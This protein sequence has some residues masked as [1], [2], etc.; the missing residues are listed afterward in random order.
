MKAPRHPQ[1][2][3]GEKVKRKSLLVA[4]TAHGHQHFPL[5]S[6]NELYTQLGQ[7][8]HH[9]HI[10]DRTATTKHEEQEAEALR[11]LSA[12]KHHAAVALLEDVVSDRV[13]KGMSCWRQAERLVMLC[14]KAACIW[15]HSEQ[16]HESPE[17]LFSKAFTI[18]STSDAF[19]GFRPLRSTLLST[20]LNNQAVYQ[21]EILCNHS[22]AEEL[23]QKAHSVEG[24]NPSAVTLMNMAALCCVGMEEEGGVEVEKARTALR[25]AMQAA[26]ISEYFVKVERIGAAVPQ[27]VEM[28][29]RFYDDH[30]TQLATSQFI[31]ARLRH[32]LNETDQ[33]TLLMQAALHTA[34]SGLPPTHPLIK[35]IRDESDAY[36]NPSARPSPIPLLLQDPQA[37]NPPS[38][39]LP[40]MLRVPLPADILSGLPA[41][42][43]AGVHLPAIE[44]RPVSDGQAPQEYL[45]SDP[46]RY[47]RMC[48]IHQLSA[49]LDERFRKQQIPTGGIERENRRGVAAIPP[50]RS[51]QS[52]MPEDAGID[53]MRVRTPQ[54][55]NGYTT[56]SDSFLPDAVRAG[57]RPSP[58][59]E[60]KERRKEPRPPSQ[61][62]SGLQDGRHTPGRGRQLTRQ[63]SPY[64]TAPVRPIKR[65][66]QQR[67]VPVR[68]QAFLHSRPTSQPSSTRQYDAVSVA[69]SI[70]SEVIPPIPPVPTPPSTPL[71]ENSQKKGKDAIT[72]EEWSIYEALKDEISQMEQGEVQGGLNSSVMSVASEP[73]TPDNVVLEAE[74][75]ELEV[76]MIRAFSIAFWVFKACRV[77]EAGVMKMRRD[78]AVRKRNE[79][80]IIVVQRQCRRHVETQRALRV[81]AEKRVVRKRS[82]ARFLLSRV[83]AAAVARNVCTTLLFKQRALREA[84]RLRVKQ[85]HHAATK[86]QTR[87]RGCLCRAHLTKREHAI[88]VLQRTARLYAA[89]N[90]LLRVVAGKRR[91]RVLY[92]S[93]NA[94]ATK[95]CHAWR[96]MLVCRQARHILLQRKVQYVD[97]RNTREAVESKQVHDDALCTAHR[98]AIIVQRCA[99][100]RL[101]TRHVLR[102]HSTLLRRTVSACTVQNAW[103]GHLSY[104]FQMSQQDLSL[105]LHRMLARCELL[106]E[107]AIDIQRVIRGF[108][109]RKAARLVQEWN[110]LLAVKA[111]TVQRV[112]RGYLGR[113]HYD[114]V[115][116]DRETVRLQYMVHAREAYSAVLVQ[117]TY[118]RFVDRRG[119]HY[120]KETKGTIERM[121]K[122]IQACLL[123]WR[124][125]KYAAERRAVRDAR[126]KR[127]LTTELEVWSA[128][129]IQRWWRICLPNIHPRPHRAPSTKEYVIREALL[130]SVVLLQ[131]C[132]RGWLARK[133]EPKRAAVR[134][135][136]QYRSY[137]LK[138][139]HMWRKRCIVV[140]RDAQMAAAERRIEGVQHNPNI[141]TGLVGCL[142]VDVSLQCEAHSTALC[143][144]LYNQC[145][146][147]PMVTTTPPPVV[148]ARLTPMQFIASNA[149]CVPH[150]RVMVMYAAVN[151]IGEWWGEREVE[152]RRRGQ[153]RA[154]RH[155]V[156][157]K[158]LWRRACR[159]V[160]AVQRRE[161]GRIQRVWRGYTGRQMAHRSRADRRRALLGKA[162]QDR[163]F[164][165][166]HVSAPSLPLPNELSLEDEVVLYAHWCALLIQRWFRK[167]IARSAVLEQRSAYVLSLAAYDDFEGL[168]FCATLIQKTYRGLRERRR[169][170]RMHKAA[171]VIQ[172]IVLIIDAKRR[173]A[174]QR[175]R[176]LLYFMEVQETEF[177][178]DPSDSVSDE[179]N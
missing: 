139:D 88:S 111:T 19:L 143:R 168:V 119:V 43:F 176:R 31:Q 113:K 37:N 64:E 13:H 34:S 73:E 106:Q 87:W 33:A 153:K 44:A 138:L 145:G 81:V 136:L 11:L 83:C 164:V 32:L 134:C 122:R 7:P 152:R 107:S 66:D 20:I 16:L 54:K 114:T 55:S 161:A 156:Y 94:A 167:I 42:P 6:K 166:K 162:L 30:S 170:A 123:G 108:L 39:L 85:R 128:V 178:E 27:Q 115:R 72:A 8:H 80:G 23:L 75:K 159:K 157:V 78:D 86:I 28:E 51:I 4:Q 150:I 95:I 130:Y 5:L 67:H 151:R 10:A 116:I 132:V 158:M 45:S 71:R 172:S 56:R 163:G 121:A 58:P 79:E 29:Q 160:V 76:Q 48:D 21:S 14:N 36:L 155:V 104:A 89:Y 165:E 90:T 12:G 77:M 22:T 99:A 177:K 171:S 146:T 61:T 59:V 100:S 98:M 169:I 110:N 173:V 179:E 140:E 24:D 117:A 141:S 15:I 57:H 118:R 174:T 18:A 101:S 147:P 9:H 131:S 142:S 38:L 154:L 93:A 127:V 137:S 103:R 109:G 25:Y 2:V 135:G 35:Q 129:R 60:K 112:F 69:P 105:R 96:C 70:P 126:R 92:R 97:S 68:P 84:E 148:P 52:L 26:A 133:K 40:Y 102:A 82:D 49:L 62:Y 125:R 46:Q 50:R 91:W 1:H 17:Q 74:Q 120:L 53:P 3:K 63:H 65:L 144:M 149:V 47:F 124:A 175:Q 41:D